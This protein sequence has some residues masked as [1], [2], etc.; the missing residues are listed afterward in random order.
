LSPEASGR[1]AAG[2]PAPGLSVVLATFNR[3]ATLARL[4]RQLSVQTLPPD[5]FEVIL[6]DD[7]S[8]P[9]VGAAQPALPPVPFCLKLVRQDNAGTPLARHRGMLEA[10]GEIV[11]V[12]DDDMQVEPGFLA[13]HLA[14]H[15]PGTRR[16]VV[17][18]IRPSAAVAGMPLFERFHAD[19][20]DRW[21]SRPVR[22]DILCTGNV[23]LRRADYQEVGGFDTSLAL[24]E[25]M[26]LGLR[27]EQ[28]GVEVV[29]AEEAFTVHDSDHRD[30]AAWRR[31]AFAYGRACLRIG[32]KLPTLPHADPWRFY[33]GG[34]LAKRPFVSLALAFP[35]LGRLLAGAVHR[36][37]LASDRVG[38]ER[39][40][41][42]LTGLL[43][44][45]E[46]FRGVRAEAGSLAGTLRAR[47]EYLG[48]VEAAVGRRVGAR[49]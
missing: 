18:Q 9:P 14:R 13:A 32:R 39:L 36:A 31:R 7:G 19:L 29:F 17:G 41:L 4:L 42:R 49:P 22:G 33:F 21:A 28:A 25:D 2:R 46:F 30:F 48:K 5:E 15:A 1:G 40:A 20:L 47:A 35:R 27:L 45:V 8:T 23:S 10:R 24:A 11:V 34:A 44:D 37:A 16:V 43:W 26:E 38:L 12:T 3:A 6:V